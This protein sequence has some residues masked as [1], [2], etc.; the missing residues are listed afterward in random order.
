[1]VSYHNLDYTVH[2]CESLTAA[3]PDARK[4][5]RESA[6]WP[7]GLE[8]AEWMKD[9]VAGADECRMVRDPRELGRRIENEL[10]DALAVNVRCGG[11]TIYRD[12]HPDYDRGWSEANRI[13]RGQKPYWDLMLDYT[14]GRKEYSWTLFPKKA[15]GDFAGALVNGEGTTRQ[16]AGQ[17]CIVVTG[18]GANIR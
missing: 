6:N 15:G 14:P 12:P 4:T 3:A 10:L 18:Q 8:P 7:P 5:L 1:M 2:A 9:V 13:L 11:V 17:I 16:A